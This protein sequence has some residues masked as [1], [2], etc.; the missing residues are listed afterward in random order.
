MKWH[1]W[2]SVLLRKVPYDRTSVLSVCGRISLREFFVSHHLKSFTRRCLA[3]VCDNLLSCHGRR[4]RVSCQRSLTLLLCETEIIPRSIL[5]TTFE[6]INYIL[7]ALGDGSLF[8]FTFD[9]D[10]GALSDRKKVSHYVLL[11]VYV[12]A[13]FDGYPTLSVFNVGHSWDTAYTS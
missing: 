3:V 11:R 6:S 9:A 5:L 8:Y 7:C 1:V 13:V 4:R 2:I 12:F 10:T